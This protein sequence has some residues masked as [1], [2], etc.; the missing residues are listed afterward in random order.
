[1]KPNP[2]TKI[3]SGEAVPV[4]GQGT[5]AMGE[6]ARRAA[7][8]ATALRIGLD[9][10]MTLIDTAEMYGNGGAEEVVADAIAGRRD[11]VFLVSKV[12]PSNASERGVPRA[13]EASLRRLGTDYLDLYLYHWR[14]GPD[15]SETIEALERLVDQGKIRHWGVSNLD[16]D[17]MEE[18]V[19]EASGE[20]VQTNQVLYNL[21]RRGIEFD[22]L[23]WLEKRNIPIMAYSPI[24]QG[25]L[26]NHATLKAIA[27][28]RN[29]TPAQ[30]ALAW[31]LRQDGMIAIPKA[32]SEKH[33][34]E[35][36]AA[37]D[38]VLSSDDLAE[39]DK[40]FPPPKR[41]RSLEML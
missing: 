30:I 5:W 6:Q 38:V 14:G 25:R 7:D 10:G 19:A 40:A 16:V 17:D 27:A 2:A 12:L 22:L 13:C 34:R 9:L 11:E 20:R 15:F 36:R 21:T 31:M 41:K 32:A 24:E 8:E 33:V 23:P 26:L 1:M 3:P 29:A 4:L 37:V 18:W 28:R 35:N 39:L